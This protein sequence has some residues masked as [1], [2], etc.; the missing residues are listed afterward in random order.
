MLAW[1]VK[2]SHFEGPLD[3][4]LFLVT[5]QELDIL[6]LPIAEITEQYLQVVESMGIDNLEDA[7]QGHERAFG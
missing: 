5:R 1:Q 2:L 7:G 4:L 6:D 3:L